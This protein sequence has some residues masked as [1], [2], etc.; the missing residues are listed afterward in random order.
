VIG[1]GYPYAI[2]TADQTAV[3]QST[4][5]QSFFR[6]LQEWAEQTDLRMRFSRKMISKAHR[7]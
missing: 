6:I 1:S 7:R 3:L 2:E 5:R 4:D